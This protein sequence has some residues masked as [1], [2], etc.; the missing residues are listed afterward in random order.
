MDPLEI[1][2]KVKIDNINDIEDILKNKIHANFIKKK[3]KLIH[4]ISIQSKMS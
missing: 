4:I 1:E 3:D 2:V